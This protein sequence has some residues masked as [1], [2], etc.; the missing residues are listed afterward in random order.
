MRQAN[1]VIYGIL[2][3][4]GIYSVTKTP[5][6]PNGQNVDIGQEGLSDM[7]EVRIAIIYQVG[8]SSRC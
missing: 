2:L 8:S 6:Y 5:R 1:S 7:P 4:P 3:W